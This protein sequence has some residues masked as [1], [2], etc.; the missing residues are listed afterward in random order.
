MVSAT[1]VYITSGFTNKHHKDAA[2]YAASF[3]IVYTYCMQEAKAPRTHKL[4]LLMLLVLAGPLF[5][6]LTD[7]TRLPLPL[8][9]VPFAWLFLVLYLSINFVIH[10]R[11]PDSSKKRSV[12]VAGV[13][14]ALPVL[15]LVFGSIHQLTI[16][17][18]LLALAIVTC[19]SVYMAKADFIH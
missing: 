1:I 11:W 2:N 12:I 15:L 7:P 14:A 5:L 8:I 4:I 3:N 18:F 10:W 6:S 19:V 16:K 9:I 17:D 13:G